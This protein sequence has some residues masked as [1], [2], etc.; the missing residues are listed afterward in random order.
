MAAQDQVTN[1][2]VNQKG[3]QL[4]MHKRIAM[5]ENLDGKNLGSNTQNKQ[6][7]QPKNK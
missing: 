2:Q 7:I 3:D 5:G 6:V 4:P 1:K